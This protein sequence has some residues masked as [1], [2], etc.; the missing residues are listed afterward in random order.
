MRVLSVR[1]NLKKLLY[2]FIILSV[3]ISSFFAG[4]IWLKWKEMNNP[5]DS[6]RFEM[7]DSPSYM[8]QLEK[9]G[10]CAL[11]VAEMPLVM[12]SYDSYGKELSTQNL[13][14]GKHTFCM[15]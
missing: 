15:T 5:S 6:A 12:R 9:D 10:E 2:I 4:A 14:M 13:Y 7:K 3:T 1:I 11:I 8:P